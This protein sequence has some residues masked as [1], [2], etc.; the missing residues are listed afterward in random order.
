MFMT[1]G[2]K[3]RTLKFL[4]V[5]VSILIYF[6]IPVIGADQFVLCLGS[7]GHAAVEPARNGLCC[8]TSRAY[9][10]HGLSFETVS[11]EAADHCGTCFDIPLSNYFHH[12]L[13]APNPP[14]GFKVIEMPASLSVTAT[15]A[16]LQ[17]GDFLDLSP[18]LTPL[19][20][21]ALRTVIL[22]T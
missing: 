1:F 4:S 13:P 2:R 8:S 20:L 19:I 3:F 10:S 17:R 11:S 18:P 7:D 12:V 6:F 22:L 15:C 14:P 16:N 5:C 9:P 21:N